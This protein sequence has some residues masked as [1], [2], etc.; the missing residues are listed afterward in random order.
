M[1][2]SL[3]KFNIENE[4]IEN[5]FM[6]LNRED[7][8][9]FMAINSQAHSHNYYI[10]SFLY[11]GS[12]Y[13]LADFENERMFAP[14][15]LLLDIHQVHTHPE[16]SSCSIKSIA[17]S[18]AFITDQN[19]G[20]FKK[21]NKAFSHSSIQITEEVLTQLD[22][23]IKLI[24]YQYVKKTKR[25]ELIKALLNV[26]VI[27]CGILAETHPKEIK[28]VDDLYAKFRALLIQNYTIHHD[29]TF[30]ANKLNVSTN[31]LT[32]KVKYSTLKT[33]KQLIDEHLLLEAKRLLYWSRITSKELAWKLGFESDS[34]FNRFFK[35]H[36]SITPKQFQMQAKTDEANKEEAVT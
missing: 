28:N 26:L 18:S 15:I 20:F 12:V 3:S 5:D 36:T 24:E 14:A 2:D 19:D 10:L 34:Y 29:V 7:L 21:L 16:M 8:N 9:R 33:P 32:Q 25:T 6:Y 30:Y 13:H 35:K 11:E 23:I 31:V 4:M 17:F 1:N 22:I 27:H